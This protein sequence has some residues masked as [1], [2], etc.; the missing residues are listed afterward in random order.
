M[1]G[2]GVFTS[3]GFQLGS[4][5]NTWTILILWICGGLLALFGA[6]AYAELGTNFKESGGDYIY[7][8]RIFHPLLGYLSA[9]AGLTVGFSAPIALAAMA[10]TKY[11]TPFGLENNL[12]LAIGVIVL[13]ALM[14]S[15]TIRHSSRFHNATTAIKVAFILVL[16]VVGFV[17]P[18]KAENALLFDDSF[19]GEIFTGGFAVSMIYVSFA[20]TGWNAA[21]YVADEID[22]PGKNLPRA[23]VQSTLFVAVT[24]V[25]FQYVLLRH[26][27][28]GELQNREEV[29]YISFTNVLGETG[30]KWVSVFIAIQLVATISS[31]LWVGPRVTWA[32][33]SENRAWK[34]LSGKNKHGIPVAATW[35]QVVMSI[36]LTLTGSFEKVLLYSGFVLQL[37]A[38][39]TVATSLFIKNP[40]PGSFRSPF[41]PTL[42][43]IFLLFNTAVLIFTV[44]T[45]PVETLFG[46]G[47]LL[48]GAGIYMVDKRGA[49]VNRES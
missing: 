27:G 3:V 28:V 41:K 20:Y 8:S 43:I 19:T 45:R 15:F 31:Y 47:L 36:I 11:L 34:I 29:T 38:S 30:G 4:L 17:F 21:A 13:I 2:T 1:I 12:W 22:Y 42:Q 37:M 14:H 9:W 26:A 24:Y 48:V 44:V 39:L 49:T 6:F 25:L 18:P 35:A 7:L 10:F 46:L 16:I 5:Q 33:A 40:K 23:L 32:M